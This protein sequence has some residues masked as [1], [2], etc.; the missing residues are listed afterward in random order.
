MSKLNLDDPQLTAY[1]LGELEGAAAAEVEKLLQENPDARAYVEELRGFGA[2]LEQD[3]AAERA[4]GLTDAQKASI[5]AAV[6]LAPQGRGVRGEGARARPTPHKAG[7]LPSFWLASAAALLM[8][9]LVGWGLLSARHPQVVMAPTYEKKAVGDQRQPAVESEHDMERYD[10]I[11]NSKSANGP[12]SDSSLAIPADVMA[13]AEIGDHF[14][15]INRMQSESQSAFGNNTARAFHSVQG[16]TKP[17]PAAP[18]AP[19]LGFI[20]GPNPLPPQVSQSSSSGSSASSSGGS[21]SSGGAS[22]WGGL[23]TEYKK[24]QRDLEALKRE[25]MAQASETKFGPNAPV[26]AKTGDANNTAF[27]VDALRSAEKDAGKKLNAS[28]KIEK[29]KKISNEQQHALVLITDGTEKKRAEGELE[30]TK[31]ALLFIEQQETIHN[32]EQYNRIFEN[33][34]KIVRGDDAVSTF[35]IDVD[36]ASYSNMRRMIKQGQLPPADAVRIEELINY[37]SYD[38]APPTDDKPFSSHVEVAECPWDPHH[39]LVRVGLKGKEIAQDKRPASNIVFLLD[40]SGSMNSPE[41]LPLVKDGLK[42]MVKQLGENDTVSIVVYAG[43]SGLVLPATNGLNQQAILDALDRLHAGGS[44]HGS[45]GIKLA[46]ETAAANFIKGGVNRVILC[47]DGD[48][49]VGTTGQGELVKL[50]EEKVKTGVFLSVLG[51]GMGN[52]KDGT[53][54]QLADKGNGHYAYIDTLQE[55]KKV[56]VEEMSSTLVTIAKDVKI[57]VEFNPAVA[58]AYRLIGYENRVM[59][60]EDFNND[61]K[62]AGEIGAG[63]SVTALYEVVP[64]EMLA[65]PAAQADGWRLEL[66]KIEKEIGIAQGRL[67]RGGRLTTDAHEELEAKLAKLEPQAEELRRRLA[68]TVDPLKY[69]KPPVVSEAAQNGELLTLKLRYKAPD[70][71]KSKLLEYPVKDSGAKWKD[72]SKEYRFAASVAAFGMLL[73]DSQYKG[74]GNYDLVLEL[75][76][77]GLAN[78]KSGYRAEFVELIKRA[79]ELSRGR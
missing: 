31:A 23:E 48:W 4:P 66:E 12:Y 36:T 43:A 35:S 50:I 57:Q 69:Q 41:R 14:E 74:L 30:N 33:S 1:A 60:R 28:E 54:E 7:F 3:L 22:G 21:S 68:D 63:H 61:A 11:L 15:T 32:A 2:R 75:A 65:G 16:N 17:S 39:R 46:Y 20:D 77:E 37:F 49:N 34:F 18:K 62:D 8:V 24:S 52:L 55:A 44:T 58:G 10:R 72:S 42:L 59:A 5:V 27:W 78:D 53:M 71:D 13:K 29:L 47:T 56:L 25:A 64:L 79:K 9:A 67:S 19:F 6:P 26:Y 40:V 76:Q 73:R 51:Y 45:A 70:E 38:Y